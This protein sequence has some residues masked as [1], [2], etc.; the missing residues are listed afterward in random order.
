MKKIIILCALLAMLIP[1]DVFA[2]GN[3]ARSSLDRE[4]SIRQ[5]QQQRQA[6]RFRAIEA[7]AAKAIESLTTEQETGGNP[8]IYRS[9]T[10]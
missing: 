1:P 5:A 3:S 10:K 7:D 4:W 2:G 9:D 6:A 8:S